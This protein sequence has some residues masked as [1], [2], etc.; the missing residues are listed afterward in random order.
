[1]LSKYKTRQRDYRINGQKGKKRIREK[2]QEAKG[3]GQTG[4]S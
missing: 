1:M 2:E 3:D 4:K